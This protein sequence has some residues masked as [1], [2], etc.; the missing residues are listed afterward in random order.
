MEKTLEQKVEFLEWMMERNHALLQIQNTMG[1]YAYMHTAGMHTECMDLFALD[2]PGTTVEMMW[3]VYEGREG[4]KRCYEGWHKDSDGE[5]KG[6]MHVHALST[7][8]IEIADDL[9]TAK[10]VWLSP[11]HETGPN[12]NT[13]KPEAYWAWMKYG[14]DF[15]R[16][17]REWK[18]WHLHVYG[19]FFTPYDKSWVESSLQPAFAPP[20]FDMLPE[21]HRPDRAPTTNWEY[22]V[23]KKYPSDQPLLPV[24]YPTFD[25][26]FSY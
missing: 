23:D 6:I 20:T 17:G 18:I 21:A 14:V 19:I 10:A 11:G 26:T 7:P 24:Q 13:G 8:V 5:G 16:E 22:K 25:K 15:I 3:G 9:K 1:R 12:P 4:I 2:T